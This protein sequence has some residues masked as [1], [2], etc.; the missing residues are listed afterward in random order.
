MTNLNVI[1]ADDA[2]IN[3]DNID[4]YFEACQDAL[5]KLLKSEK[6]VITNEY[7]VNLYERYGD[8]Y[9]NNL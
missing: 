3:E 6:L 5:K 7:L 9:D 4:D 8:E 1:V 2:V